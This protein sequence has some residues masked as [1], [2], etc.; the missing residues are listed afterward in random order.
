MEDQR[1]ELSRE[2][3]EAFRSLKETR[4]QSLG[5]EDLI[6]SALKT[7][8]LIRS[9]THRGHRWFVRTAAAAAVLAGTFFVGVQYG[10]KSSVPI[11]P[12][13][14]PATREQSEPIRQ[15]IDRGTVEDPSILDEY[16]DEPDRP[17]NGKV[18][19]AG[20]VNR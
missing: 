19:V 17:G 7:R 14:T 18:L 2:E 16:R 3:M 1:D 8:G 4:N 9:S 6:V 15:T 11:D 13:V 12:V 10:R 20:Y 5:N